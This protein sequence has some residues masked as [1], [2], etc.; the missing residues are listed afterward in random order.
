M[1][2][3]ALLALWAIATI[4]GAVNITLPPKFTVVVCADFVVTHH[5]STNVTTITCPQSDPSYVI[6]IPDCKVKLTPDGSGG[7]VLTCNG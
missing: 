1:R 7:Y 6:T 2:Y 4:A 3:I 5:S